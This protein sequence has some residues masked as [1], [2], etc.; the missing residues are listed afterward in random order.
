MADLPEGA[1]V[2]S[3]IPGR[4][5]PLSTIYTTEDY[6]EDFDGIDEPLTTAMA[7]R[8]QHM[9]SAD[10]TEETPAEGSAESPLEME[11]SPARSH[12]SNHS[13]VD[14]VEM[15]T[16]SDSPPPPSPAKRQPKVFSMTTSARTIEF[17]AATPVDVSLLGPFGG[18]EYVETA[19]L[20]WYDY[21]LKQGDQQAADQETQWRVLCNTLIAF[22]CN[23]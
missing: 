7:G 9:E 15:F 21:R 5:Q 19:F 18:A 12:T 8:Y 16:P 17:L 4:A 10:D 3:S 13:S 6:D 11:D 2:A 1:T 23:A 22:R 20:G 14:K